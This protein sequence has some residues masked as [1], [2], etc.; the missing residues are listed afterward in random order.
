MAGTVRSRPGQVE[1]DQLQG[2]CQALREGLKATLGDKLYGIY[3]YGAAAFPEQGFARDI[4]F[5]VILAEAL[6]DGERG[7]IGELHRALARDFPPLGA[8]LD[9][10]Y[11]L[12]AEARQTSPPVH[13]LRPDISDESWALHREHIRA[14]RCISVYGPE[15]KQVYPPATWAELESALWGELAYVEAHLDEYPDY[16]ILNLCRLMYSF[17]TGDVVVSKAMAAGWAQG[18]FPQW[19]EQIEVAMRSYAGQVTEGDRRRMKAEVRGFFDFAC[20]R[21]GS[22]TLP[23]TRPRT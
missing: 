8:D 3:V 23:A 11:I 5:H 22:V 4:D 12:L 20:E 7:A 19:G 16:C 9:G 13:Q 15:P 2:L 6:T 18:V 17:E 21:I 1:M 10:Y 14:G